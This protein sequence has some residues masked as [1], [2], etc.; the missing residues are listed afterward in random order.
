MSGGTPGYFTCD[1][2]VPPGDFTVHWDLLSSSSEPFVGPP[3]GT[4]R[5]ERNRIT[6]NGTIYYNRYDGS[7]HL[8]R[9]TYD[10]L[11]QTYD[12]VYHPAFSD[13]V[14]EWIY[15]PVSISVTDWRK[16]TPGCIEERSTY[17]ID[18][19]DNIDFDRALDLDLD[20]IPRN[21]DPDTQWR[22]RYRDM[23]YV[24]S[25]QADG[26]GSITTEEVTTTNNFADTGK[27][28]FSGCPA[29]ARKLAEMDSS[30]LDSYL[31]TLSPEGATYHDIGMIWGGRLLSPTGLFASDNA[32][33]SAIKPTNRNLIFLTDGQTEPYDLA[34]G[35]YGVDALDQ[36]RWSQSSP[37]TLAETVE[38]RFLAA[39]KEV[40]KRN[41]TVWVIAFGTELN[42]VMTECA[43]AGRYF[44]ADNSAQ[45]SAAFEAIA[46][47]LGDLRVSQ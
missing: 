38:Q 35:A 27:W 28:W 22:P 46:R 20:R 34:Y 33:V 39:C 11:I 6:E 30:T 2:A 21:N 8:E 41:I 44:E 25:I 5:I 7:C 15:R 18:D 24:R 13:A 12:H 14:T 29:P 31:A 1:G 47:S 16:D 43:G 26:S 40:K 36:R 37:M 42:P 45:L 4:K 32:D 23:I 3:A 9:V 10:N 19:Y 17:E